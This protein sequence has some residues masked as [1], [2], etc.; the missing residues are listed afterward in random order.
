MQELIGKK[1]IVYSDSGQA[2]RQ[3]IGVLESVDS[4]WVCIKK[5]ESDYLYF[6]AYK[7]RLVKAFDS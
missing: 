4:N 6:S 1:V 3:D 2:E 5:G 7:I